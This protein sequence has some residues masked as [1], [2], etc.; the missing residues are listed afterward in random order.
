M[1]CGEERGGE[2]LSFTSL[3]VADKM[4]PHVEVDLCSLGM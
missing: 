3:N 2:R 1:G 4:L